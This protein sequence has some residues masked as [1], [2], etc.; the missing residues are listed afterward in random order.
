MSSQFSGNN[1]VDGGWIAGD[2]N[3]ELVS[4]SP[5][6]GEMILEG[7]ATT[8]AQVSVAA[9]SARNAQATWWELPVESRIEFAVQ[10]ADAVKS[11]ADDLA[12]LISRENGKPLWESKTEVGAV[13]GK[14]QLSIDAFRER[15][16]TRSFAMDG[17]NAV[18][19]YKPYGVLGVLGPFNFP[20]HLP[21]GHII[22][23]LIAG[24]TIVFKPSEET[25]AVGE[26][27]V[28][29]WE[30]VGLPK[31]VI[32]LVQG[33]RETG[34]ALANES[35]LDGLLFTGSSNAGSA[36]HKTFG[37]WPQKILALEMGGNNPLIAHRFNDTQAAAYNVIL[38][39]FLTAGQ[40]CT[41][42]RRLILIQGDKDDQLLETVQSMIQGIS[43]GYWDDS[44]EPFAGPVINSKAGTNV[45]ASQDRLIKEGGISIVP[46][47]SQRNNAALVSPGLIDVTNMKER[48]DHEVFGPLL[49]VTRVGSFEEAI[50]EANN[51]A[52]GL[53]AGLLSDEQELYDHFIKHIRAGVVNWNRQTT[54]AS[55]KLPFGG[56]GLSGNSRPGGYF[57]ADYC[58]WPVASLESDQLVMP[59]KLMNGLNFDN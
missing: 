33:G 20:A 30:Q 1:F 56:C 9:I 10:F 23:A 28:R 26:W 48:S 41:C 12:K 45:L 21:N 11:D 2:S 42:A 22:P 18:T 58:N 34:V 35:Q 59:E 38:S 19:R 14:A 15:R 39:A 51:S 7:I 36:L 29:K 8:E 55:G 46:A 47:S 54:G 31:G 17:F 24:N 40:R 3:Q 43:M 52:Y 4:T 32:N 13:V 5:S 27:L 53:S 16:D 37:Q 57:A 50:E 49:Q 6:S 44:P 25:P